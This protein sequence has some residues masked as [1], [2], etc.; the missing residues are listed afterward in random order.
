MTHESPNAQQ[1][2]YWNETAGPKWV[3]LQSMIDAQIEGLGLRAMDRAGIAAGLKV[4]DVGCG[5]GQTT[6][7]LAL[8]VGPSGAV[9]AVDISAPM[10]DL[11][12]RRAAAAGVTNAS[13]QLADAQTHRFEPGTHDLLFS[14]FGVMFFADPAAAFTNL[15]RA[16]GS[17][18]RLT[19]ICWQ[20]IFEN[21]WMLVP[22]MAASQHVQMPPPPGP[23]APGPFAFADPELV[24]G[25]LSQAGFRDIAFDD[26]RD[27]LAIGAGGDL[28]TTVDFLLQMGPTARALGEAKITPDSPQFANLVKAVRESLV[29]YQTP[30]GVRMASATWIVTAKA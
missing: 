11:A 28:D 1:S 12:R 8:R 5:C 3:A 6:L 15:R 2:V 16:L 17:S 7:V 29:P 26:V 14:R 23:G 13:F 9:T 4:L 10:L 25:I 21:P 22:M 19:F 24:R 30:R 20:T 27:E 18:G